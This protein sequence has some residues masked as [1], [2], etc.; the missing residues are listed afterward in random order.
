MAATA[1]ELTLTGLQ[2]EGRDTFGHPFWDRA[3]C[4]A[5]ARAII[6]GPSCAGSLCRGLALH[7]FA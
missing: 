6:N 7:V 4:D 5:H 1:A 3:Y 2:I